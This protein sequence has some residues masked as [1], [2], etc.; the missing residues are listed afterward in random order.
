MKALAITVTEWQTEFLT[1]PLPEKL[2]TCCSCVHEGV[3]YNCGRMANWIS[4]CT[5][6][7]EIDHMLFPCAWKRWLLLLQNG[8]LN[9]LLHPYLRNWSHVVPV[10]M[11]ALAITVAEL[12]TEFLT[13]SLPEKLITSWSRVHEG[14][15]YYCGRMANWISYS[16]LTW[17]IDHMLFPCAWRRW[18]LL[19]QNGKLNFLL[20]PYLRNWSQVVPVC[21][22]ALAIIVAEW[23]T[24][25]LTAPLP[26]KLITCCSRV[27]EGISYNCG[28][29]ANWISYCILTW[30]IDHKLF[31][32]AWRR[33]L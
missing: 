25:F 7:W 23:Q 2:I 21:M 13:A 32:C 24:E 6:T 27:H 19:W 16:I 31:P 20:H 14:V 1:A 26:E 10:C 33:W 11:K 28:R 4:Y 15:G 3:G 22:K 29:M 30:E 9:F 18:P 5:L 17:E 12:Q 8:K